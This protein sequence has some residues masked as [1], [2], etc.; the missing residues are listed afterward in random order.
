LPPWEPDQARSIDIAGSQRLFP[1]LAFASA[2]GRILEIVM[3]KQGRHNAATETTHR[4]LAL[5]WR[6][7]GMD[8]RKRV[9]P[10]R[11]LAASLGREMTHT[12]PRGPSDLRSHYRAPPQ[13]G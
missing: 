3:A 10:I 12:A 1:S 7:I 4:D 5:V 9:A 2:D 8:E 13:P 6:Q 11:G